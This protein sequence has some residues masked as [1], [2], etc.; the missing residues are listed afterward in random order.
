MDEYYT[1]PE[2]EPVPSAPNKMGRLEQGECPSC[3]GTVEG[4]RVAG[5]N[6]TAECK[7]PDCDFEFI[8]VG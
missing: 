8:L 5:H 2:M 6:N 3:G 4:R 7:N 1:K